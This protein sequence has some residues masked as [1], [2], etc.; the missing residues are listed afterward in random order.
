M[1][2]RTAVLAGLL[3]AASGCA[4][5]LDARDHGVIFPTL[6]ASKKIDPIWTIDVIA[7]YAAGSDRQ[8]VPAGRFIEIGGTSLGGTVDIDFNLTT[9]RVEARAR[10]DVGYQWLVEG[11][12]GVAF[13]YVDVT[14]TSGGARGRDDQF[15]A[16]PLAGG[17]FAWSA[18]SRLQPYAETYIMY[19]FPDGI[20]P[21]G[22]VELGVEYK[23][24][25]PMSLLG[26]WRFRNLELFR[27]DSD[28][29]FEWSGPF[30]G[31]AFDF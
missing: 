14:A 8:T 28:F 21:V 19:P 22:E 11:F 5:E 25:G 7:D 6:R 31:L 20:V 24:A 10:E 2:L 13:Y 29:D 18:G 26:G 12:L 27:A 17:R 4:T 30:L 16:G 9:V 15:V 1:L 23:A 3:A